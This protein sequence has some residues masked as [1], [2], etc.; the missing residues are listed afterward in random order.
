MKDPRLQPLWTRGF[1][2]RMWTPVPGHSRHPR[3]RYNF[4]IELKTHQKAEISLMAKLSAITNHTSKKRKVFGSP[5]EATD[6]NTSGK[7]GTQIP[8]PPPGRR[9]TPLGEIM[10]YVC[11]LTRSTRLSVI[12][13]SP[14]PINAKYQFQVTNYL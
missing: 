1:W 6:G 12:I 10:Q 11:N 3:N 4:F 13:H 9:L 2:Q 8:Q 14:P 7:A 5:S